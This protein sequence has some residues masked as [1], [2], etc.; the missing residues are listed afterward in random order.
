MVDGRLRM[1]SKCQPKVNSTSNPVEIRNF[2]TDVFQRFFDVEIS[3]SIRHRNWE[4][5]R[6]ETT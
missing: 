3:T 1:A 4:I 6:W 5:A 2:D